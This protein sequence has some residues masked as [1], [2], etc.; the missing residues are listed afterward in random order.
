TTPECAQLSSA[1]LHVCPVGGVAAI[2]S[3]QLEMGHVSMA[4]GCLVTSR[5]VVPAVQAEVLLE[6]FRV[7]TTDDG[8]FK[9]LHV[10]DVGAGDPEPGFTQA[11]VRRLP[12]LINGIQFVAFLDQNG[13]D[14]LRDTVTAPS[15]KP[16]T[17]GAVVADNCLGSFSTDIPS[18]AERWP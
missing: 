4:L 13:P 5:I 2:V 1:G 18:E 6:L 12:A 7:G 16:A 14:A 15:L 17:N 8:C 10:R 3:D 11:T 9:Q